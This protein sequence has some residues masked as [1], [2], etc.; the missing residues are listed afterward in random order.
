MDIKPDI[1]KFS[2]QDHVQI[3][4]AHYRKNTSPTPNAILV[5]PGFAQH[6]ATLSMQRL[7][8]SLLG[9][10]D[11]IVP[12][13]RGNYISEGRYTFGAKEILD[14]KAIFSWAQIRYSHITLLGFS[15]GA[16]T[17]VRLCAENPAQLKCALLVSCPTRVE[18]V[19]L[20]G[21]AFY[22]PLLLPFR[23]PR[24]QH[25]PGND[26]GF[27]WGWPFLKKPNL[28]DLGSKITI[29][30]HFLVAEKDS[31]VFPRLSRKVYEAC[32]EPKTWQ[33]VKNGIHAEHMFH[34]DPGLFMD[35]VKQHGG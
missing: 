17:C 18:D 19:V 5:V 4:A 12:A 9:M 23:H 28:I 10:A 29:P 11:V 16:Y 21:G 35:W 1:L 14:L 2:T 13:F 31:L 3:H 7:A 15:L 34:Q 32:P 20:S 30:C 22:N 25:P 27:C 24:Y 8:C 26:L 33:M 6:F